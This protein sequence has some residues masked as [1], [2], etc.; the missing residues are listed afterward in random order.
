V[1]DDV[2]I[3]MLLRIN[4]VH[5]G[6]EIYE[7]TNGKEAIDQYYIYKPE[8]VIL[9]IMMPTVDGWEVCKILRDNDTE[10]K[11][12]IIMLT[13]RDTARDR[14]IGKNIL[15]ADE[16]ITKPFD[17]D[18]LLNSIENLIKSDTYHS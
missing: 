5:E 13:A 3:R 4:L 6:Y 1:D 14:I 7:A 9:D 12:K 2:H 10:G 8:L 17:I 11:L 15:K 18:Q 16:Y